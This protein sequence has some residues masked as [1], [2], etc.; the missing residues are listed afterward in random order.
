MNAPLPAHVAK[1]AMAH[2][3]SLATGNLRADVENGGAHARRD[4]TVG[5]AP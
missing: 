3:H 1:Q 4:D 2:E 5:L